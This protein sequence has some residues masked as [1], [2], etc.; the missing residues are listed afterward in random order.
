MTNKKLLQ[1]GERLK[2]TA[3]L[4]GIKLAYAVAKNAEKIDREIKVLN[5]ILEPSEA[6]LVYAKELK[7][8]QNEYCRKDASGNPVIEK[9]QYVM[10]D[11]AAFKSDY[12]AL[13]TKHTLVLAE[14]EQQIDEYNQLM[15]E[16]SDIELHHVSIDN[17]PEDITP[18]QM[19]AI[20]PF[21]DGEP[22]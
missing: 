15:D 6:Y 1:I 22:K 16:E 13:K 7:E 12:D 20:M 5:K 9:D 2:I 18:E 17:I 10:N 14:R 4:K 19:E 3:N 21:L 11:M 8:L